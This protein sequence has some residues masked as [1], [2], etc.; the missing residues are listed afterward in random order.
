MTPGIIK[1]LYHTTPVG[2]TDE[3]KQEVYPIT[4]T[5]AVYSAPGESSFPN[6][7]LDNILD[8]LN[9][10]Y[11]YMGKASPST[12]PG[13]FNH[14][15]FYLAS[16]TGT[17]SY[18]DDIT[19]SGLTVL[20]TDGNGWS[21]DAFSITGGG[22]GGLTTAYIGT[23]MVQE[24]PAPQQLSGISQLNLTSGARIYFGETAYIELNQY[25]FHFSEGIYSDSF[26]AAGGIGSG[27]GGGG[28]G[29]YTPGN[30]ISIVNDEIS[31]KI[32]TGLAFDANGNLTATG[33]GSYVLPIA[34][35]S[36]LGGIKVGS[37]LSI[38][39]SGV[40]SAIG[41]TEGTVTSITLN[42]GTGIT[43]SNSGTA[44]TT[45]GSRTISINS[46]YR[47]KIDHGDTAYSWGN[48]AAAGYAD[49]S[50]VNAA[51]AEKQNVISDLET[52]RSNASRGNTAYG[53]GNHAL[54]GYAMAADLAALATRVTNIEDWF[55]VVTV[56]GQGALHAKN[57]RAIYSDSW[58]AAG[59]VGSSS[60]GG[61]GGDGT[62]T[63]VGITM[64][65]QFN[66]S[67]SPITTSGTIAITLKS[68]YTI[69]SAQDWSSI[70]SAAHTHSNYNILESITA[71]KIAQWDAG[72]GINDVTLG[73]TSVVSNG[74]AVLPAYPTTLPASDVYSWAKASTKPSY[75]FSELTSHPTTLSGYGITD[76]KISN[77]VITLGSNTITPL[78]SS[79]IST[80]TLNSGAFSSGS[81]TPTGSSK[82][83]N[84]PTTTSHLN[85]DNTTL[86][87]F[88]DDLPNNYV[89]LS[90][91]Q[92][93]T[94]AKTFST[95]PVTIAASSGISV[96]GSSY[97]DIGDARIVYDSSNNAIHITRKNSG[98]P[99]GLYA[100]GALAAG[101]IA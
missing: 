18:F 92:I 42:S 99:V 82:S 26:V 29:S 32:G 1:K 31:V 70:Y 64:P 79:D 90:T 30:G 39:S 69:P 59:G 55:E 12:N 95:N 51:L 72:G 10:G 57:G 14:K 2:L 15:V 77:G 60:G 45:S 13:V 63:S 88:L 19:V 41:G 96:S 86:K 87:A 24:T 46:S 43:V 4:A 6:M 74:V 97:I 66:V 25:G 98:T 22:G 81:W 75:T 84:I 65:T 27:G 34:S 52:I 23:T 40:L 49:A 67:G 53:W 47:N 35:A 68:S 28:G 38:D 48:H 36:T 61:G 100:D 21:A 3:D 5:S 56:S 89:T 83:F 16:E 50:V 94:G 37:G 93:I 11:Q 7:P 91:T 73:G 54:A 33:G 17:Y 20:K 58:I 71:A 44:I 76:A 62:V 78:V 85:H 101:G 9:Q 80:L 8:A